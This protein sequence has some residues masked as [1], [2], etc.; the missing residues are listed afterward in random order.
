MLQLWFLSNTVIWSF[1]L[2]LGGLNLQANVPLLILAGGFFL[3][4]KRRVSL[5]S[6][7]VLL[8]LVAS[9]AVSLLTAVW[10]PCSDKLP[11]SLITAPILIAL[12]FV[13]WEVGRSASD[14]NW[15][16]LQKSAVAAILFAFAGFLVEFSM[17]A[18]FPFTARYR[19]SG[20]LSGFFQE[21]SAVAFS[22]FPC[23]AVLLVAESKKTRQTGRWLLGGLLLIS[24]SSTLLALIAAW[25]L[26]RL[27]IHRRLRQAFLFATG[28]AALLGLASAVNY[29]TLVAPTVDRIAGL[30]LSDQTDNVSSL[31]YIQGWQDAWVNLTHTHGL[32]L[33]F[34]MMGCHPLPDVPTRALLSLGGMGELNAENGSFQFSKTVSEAGIA[35]IAFYVAAI[36]WWL[37]LEKRIR[38]LTDRTEHSVF[39]TQAALMFCF[40]SSSFIR[41]EGYFSGSLLLWLVATSASWKAQQRQS[42]RFTFRPR[43]LATE[44]QDQ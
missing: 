34:N 18:W 15:L 32:G 25:I 2:S 30:A 12:V 27:V 3:I 36:W 28:F 7:K 38:K 1:G 29:R 37:R 10:G 21:P 13:G 42:V 5:S 23:I 6:G 9:A 22:L 33:G 39:A 4:K 43:K 40:L 41:G 44:A 26:Y 19:S 24:R 35:G 31:V 14:T 8:F 16:G 20:R 11:K 17:P